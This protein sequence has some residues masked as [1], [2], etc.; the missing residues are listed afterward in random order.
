[1]GVLA[2]RWRYAKLGTFIYAI[3][4]STATADVWGGRFL[5]D[6]FEIEPRNTLALVVIAFALWMDLVGVYSTLIPFYRAGGRTWT[7]GG[8]EQFGAAGGY[9]IQYVGVVLSAATVILSYPSL[10]AAGVIVISSAITVWLL[11]TMLALILC[12][13]MAALRFNALGSR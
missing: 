3:A 9:H 2:T 13:T 1:M 6:S 7:R 11:T 5:K 4:Y 10:R 8:R 12:A